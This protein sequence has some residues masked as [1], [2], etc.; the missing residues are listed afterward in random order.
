MSHNG[1]VVIDDEQK[2]KQPHKTVDFVTAL[3]RGACEER[4]S[5]PHTLA[6][7]G[8][9]G[10]L[11]PAEQTV[12]L[13]PGGLFII[14]RR[15]GG[16]LVPIRFTGNLDDA[17]HSDGTWVHGAL[18][19]D[20]RNQV[21]IEGMIVF[22]TFFLLTALLFLRLKTRAFIISGP[23]LILLLTLASIRWRMLRR[24]ADDTTR[25]LR[26]RLYVTREQAK[27]LTGRVVG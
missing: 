24:Y 18:T 13:Q 4:L 22:L 5:R 15:Y 26:H 16:A 27:P 23:A 21:M 25:W 6:S 17:P 3:S 9:G 14:E 7:G 19:H 20:T 11:A 2:A 8:L 12:D 10:L 1:K